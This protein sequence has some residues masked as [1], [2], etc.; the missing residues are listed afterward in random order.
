MLGRERS[1]HARADRSGADE[2][3]EFDAGEPGHDVLRVWL[4]AVSYRGKK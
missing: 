1:M 4:S 3:E 2:A